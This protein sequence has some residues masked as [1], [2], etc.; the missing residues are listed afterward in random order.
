MFGLAYFHGIL[1]FVGYLMPESSLKKDSR[2][3]IPHIIKGIGGSCLSQGI[4]PKVSLVA[5]LEI[6]P[7][8]VFL[9]NINNLITVICFPVF[10][11]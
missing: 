8:Q 10:S 11:R 2:A 7:F 4:C 6:E 5:R 1:N 3:T 9:S